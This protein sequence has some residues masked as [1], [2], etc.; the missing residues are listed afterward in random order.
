[1]SNNPVRDKKEGAVIYYSTLNDFDIHLF[2]E[3]RHFKLYEKLG[4]HVTVFD[5]RTG[6]YFGVWAPN[7]AKVSVIGN[8]NGWNPVSHQ[9]FNR[10]DGSG[11]WEGFIPGIGHGEVYKY[12]IESNYNNYSVEK[13]DPFALMW[14]EAPRTASIVW[15]NKFSWTDNEWMKARKKKIDKP[16]PISVYEIHIGSWRRNPGEG[17]RYLTYG[18]LA[19]P[20]P[21]Y[22]KE[23]GYTHVEFMPVMEHPFYGSWGYQVTGYFAP[24][25]RYGSP[26]DFMFLINELHREGIGVILDWVPSHFPSDQ[27]GLSFFDGTHLYE[28][29]DPREGYHPDWKS[30]IFNYG[31]NEVRCF[32]ISNAVFWLDIYHADGLRVDA[33]AS[34]L[35]RDYSRKEGEWI[36]NRFG[37]RENL[38]A[39]SFIKQVN[40]ATH[41]GFPD[42]LTIAEE[43][44]AWPMV[45]Q[46]THVGG[47]GFDMK[48]MMGWMHDTLKYFSK[49]PVYRQYHQN[50][51][52]FSIVYAFSEKYTLPLSH[53]EVVHGKGSMIGKMP[54]DQW[55]RFS[56]LRLLYS[57]MFAHPGSKLLFMGNEFAQLNEWNH[58]SSLDW[59]LLAYGLHQGVK[60]TLQKL[61]SIYSQEKAFY[62]CQYD[63]K[64]FEW[65]D[66]GDSVNSVISFIRR[67]NSDDNVIVIVCNF[68]PVTRYDYQIGVP[69]EGKWIELFNSDEGGLGGSNIMNQGQI[70]SWKQQTHG[71]PFTL[72]LTLPPLGAVYLKP[73]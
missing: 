56:N 19:G 65:I 26:Q 39:I 24:S 69:L 1:M 43:S 18:E 30:F 51:I 49:D 29:Q 55:Q 42:I 66:I 41:E 13:G 70:V 68:T 52:T 36:P 47:L 20:L 59:H 11:I 28:H 16:G 64:G 32:L 40:E 71:R 9:L 34:M 73:G 37:G 53:D 44:T 33:V 67:G 17:N 5:G 27:H 21:A 46:P 7:A 8:F 63:Q 3:G 61:N 45:S 48:W 2:R 10:D 35:Y 57:Y 14:E 6:T 50:D 60:K 72:S 25:S 15:D 58:D 31:R 22:L 38:E 62:E 12:K 23:M 4:S 54:G